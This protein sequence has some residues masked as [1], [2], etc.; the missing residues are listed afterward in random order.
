MSQDR[1]DQKLL[2]YLDVKSL[3]DKI[4]KTGMKVRIGVDKWELFFP[5]ERMREGERLFSNVLSGHTVDELS[6]AFKAA[7][8][9][10][11]AFWPEDETKTGRA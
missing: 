9:A 2:D 5:A 10:R 7:R 3:I 1:V 4:E 6:I 11:E 8:N